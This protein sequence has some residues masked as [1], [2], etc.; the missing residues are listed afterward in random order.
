MLN[1]KSNFSKSERG[2]RPQLRRPEQQYIISYNGK[3]FNSYWR[4]W[5]N[6]IISMWAK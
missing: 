6:L 1:L 2:G 5:Y 3:K 4:L